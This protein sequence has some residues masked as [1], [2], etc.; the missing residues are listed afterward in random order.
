MAMEFQQIHCSCQ[1]HLY[2]S[3]DV[4]NTILGLCG[5]NFLEKI[6]TI[7]ISEHPEVR[8]EV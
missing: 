4:P 8:F 1:T 7:D 6:Q 5:K 2:G 3:E